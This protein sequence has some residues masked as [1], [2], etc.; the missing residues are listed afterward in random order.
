MK[1]FLLNFTDLKFEALYKDEFDANE[2]GR[3]S[4]FD[5]LVINSA[6]SLMQLKAN[7]I[8]KLRV[9]VGLTEI[10]KVDSKFK[11]CQKIWDTVNGMD[12]EIVSVEVKLRK[13]SI[14]RAQRFMGSY[15]KSML[16][17]DE[18]AHMTDD[19]I[20]AD[21]REHFPNS[22]KDSRACLYWYRTRKNR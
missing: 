13:K 12:W 19:E 6:D 11:H 2:A 14:P 22:K 17:S 7:H 21:I 10:K 20:A 3:K 1:S 9:N 16:Y 5:Y 15:V 18:W 4:N 8:I